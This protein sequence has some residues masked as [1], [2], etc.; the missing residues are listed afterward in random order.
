MFSYFSYNFCWPVRTLRIQ[1]KEKRWQKRTPAMAAGL[2]NH[3]W[4]LSEWLAYPVRPV[5]RTQVTTE[6]WSVESN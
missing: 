5:P 4:S 1:D 6:K 3:V 2:T